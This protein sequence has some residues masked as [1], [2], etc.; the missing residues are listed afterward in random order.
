MSKEFGDSFLIVFFISGHF[1][2]ILILLY[3]LATKSKGRSTFYSSFCQSVIRWSVAVST[4][5]RHSFR[6]MAF[7][8]AVA[9]P[10]FR[11]SRSA[12]IARSQVSERT[13]QLVWLGL[14]AGRFQSGGI[15]RTRCKGSM[16]VLARWTAS[17]MAE[18]SQTFSHHSPGEKAVI[19][20]WFFWLP[21]STHGKYTVS[22]RSC[23]I[24]A[25]KLTHLQQS[26]LSWTSSTLA[27]VTDRRQNW[28]SKILSIFDFVDRVDFRV[29]N[30]SP[31]CTRITDRSFRYASPRLWNQLPDSFRQPHQSCLDSPPHPL[32]N[33]FSRFSAVYQCN[34][35][36]TDSL[37]L[38]KTELVFRLHVSYLT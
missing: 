34:S 4:I 31:V 16:V 22:S 3:K 6:V 7:L 25:T 28:K 17:N 29:S 24:R 37:D 33:P 14:P 10:K 30:L 15:C 9:R 11:G 19:N 8:Q 23:D 21:H 27:T 20:Q 18:E 26:R 38:S 1:L 5:C 12:S 32:L 13:L 2:G 35:C 36:A